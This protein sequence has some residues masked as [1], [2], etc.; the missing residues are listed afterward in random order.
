LFVQID[1]P[2]PAVRLDTLDDDVMLAAILHFQILK[3]K[4]GKSSILRAGVKL[5]FTE[6]VCVAGSAGKKK[7]GR[8][9]GS[10]LSLSVNSLLVRRMNQEIAHAAHEDHGGDAHNNNIGIVRSSHLPTAM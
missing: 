10:G 6:Q 9:S 3:T 8:F 7:P 5:L 2:F 1:G 4:P